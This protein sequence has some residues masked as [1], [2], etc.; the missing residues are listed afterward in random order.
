LDTAA[1]ERLMNIR[2]ETPADYADI[3]DLQVHAFGGQIAEALLI[4]FLRQRRDF[5]PELSLVAEVDQRIVGHVLFSPFSISLLG[6]HIK[7]VILAPLG[8]ENLYQRQGIGEALVQQGHRVA[9]SKDCLVSFVIGY[10]TFF[11]RFGY[12]TGA[13]GLSLLTLDRQ[14]VLPSSTVLESRG[15]TESDCTALFAL[16]MGEEYNVDF[17]MG[18][19]ESLLDWISP[20]PNVHARVY[21]R[22]GTVV[23]YTRVHKDEPDK[24]RIFL[25]Y[26][27]DAAHA[28]AAMLMKDFPSITLTLHPF[29]KS[30]AAFA[31]KPQVTPW[32]AAMACS[33]APNPFEDYYAQIQAGTRPPGRVNLPVAFDLIF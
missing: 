20:N 1:F 28:M 30:A 13:F 2:P 12:K 4:A 17:A 9:L 26:D 5:D 27:K 24:P 11:P 25:A 18:Q 3:A 10:D 29:T 16:A 6:Q 31:V 33:L 8:I 14:Q 15:P 21:L 32:K 22:H 23:G 19:G 7:A